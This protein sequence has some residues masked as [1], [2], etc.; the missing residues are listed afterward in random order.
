[1]PYTEQHKQETRKRI[2]QSARRLFNRH[3]F[4]DVSIDDI[5]AGAG[6]TRGGFYKH[7]T[8]KEDLYEEAVLEFIC[9]GQ[10]E[11]WQASHIDPAARGVTLSRMILDAYLSQDHFDDRDGSCP[12]IALPSDVGRGSES[13]K[14]AFRQ[15][16]AMMVDTFAGTLGPGPGSSRERALALT[17]MM[18]GGMVL[19]RA[20]D[21]AM[22]AGELR[23][24][25]RAQ[26]IALAGWEIAE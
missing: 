10:P 8:G 13:V 23:R 7:F 15:V 22:L 12:L 17:A 3:G 19:A 16:L 1:M 4:A 21:D 5:M 6:L 25:A 24:S 2:I 20:V 18:V 9:A 14:G 11:A 26:A